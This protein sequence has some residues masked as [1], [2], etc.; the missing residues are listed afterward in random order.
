VS[1]INHYGSVDL[2][3]ELCER[4]SFSTAF[5]YERNNWTSQ[6]VGDERNGAYENVYQG[7]AILSYRVSETLKA[8][9]GVQYSSRKE[10]F[11]ADAATKLNAG[12][13]LAARF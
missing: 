5:H 3:V 6:L 13:G 9:T 11:E 2:E 1:Y 8:Y 12:L 10:S 7:E 4:L